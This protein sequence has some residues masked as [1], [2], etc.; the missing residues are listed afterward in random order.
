MFSRSRSG[1]TPTYPTFLL[2]SL[3]IPIF[4]RRQSSITTTS[5]A[6]SNNLPS[7]SSSPVSTVSTEA[8]PSSPT[9]IT[10][11]A[12]ETHTSQL[13][14]DSKP[15]SDYKATTTPLP[16]H[17]PTRR[18]LTSPL[19]DVIRC[20][21][22]G[23]D[24]AYGLQIVSKGFTGRHG[25]GLLVGAPLAASTPSCPGPLAA[26]PA[27]H[28]ASASAT[29]RDIAPGHH[30]LA[31]ESANLVNV[32]VSSPE[33]RNLVTGAHVVAD[34][35]CA[36]CGVV[37]GWKY[38]DAREQAQK[39][40][41]GKFILEVERTVLVRSW[42]NGTGKEGVLG[43]HFYSSSAPVGSGG[44]RRK[45]EPLLFGGR[46]KQST[47]SEGPGG[48]CAFVEED[49]EEGEEDDSSGESEEEIAFD[50]EDEDECEDIFAGVW[51]AATVARRR[52]SRVSNGSRRDGKKGRPSR[53]R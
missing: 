12:T 17:D 34:I 8:F 7:L 9:I 13:P 1:P 40:K 37:V 29:T 44:G 6:L 11:D 43:R 39:Y 41:V 42:E 36:T 3:K 33:P 25:R 28:S 38:V 50:S 4:R 14:V 52:G 53:D 21:T 45:S 16:A 30:A 15:A 2:P 18:R 10:Q 27:S 19:P 51:D 24:L 48:V 32:T 20:S 22:C 5:S 35:R 31:H 46:R 49:E 47:S 26:P 23:T